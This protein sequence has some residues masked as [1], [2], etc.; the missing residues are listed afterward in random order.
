MIMKVFYIAQN[1]FKKLKNIKN[2]SV[3]KTLGLGSHE[4][5]D[6]L[7]HMKFLNNIEKKFNIKINERNLNNFN[8]IQNTAKFFIENQKKFN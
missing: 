3:I 1:S 6:S 4:E 2:I 5:W 7:N 8:N